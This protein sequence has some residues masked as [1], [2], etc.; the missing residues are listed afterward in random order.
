VL[1][2]GK[3]GIN[4]DNFCPEESKRVRY[5]LSDWLWEPVLGC[6]EGCEMCSFKT[7]PHLYPFFIESTRGIPSAISAHISTPALR[8]KNT[9]LACRYTDLFSPTV[10]NGIKRKV[11]EIIRE[12]PSLNFIIPT[13]FPEETRSFLLPRNVIVMGVC[14]ADHHVKLMIER[15]DSLI[16]IVEAALF[17]TPNV[18]LGTALG[19][20]F[21]F[22]EYD[23]L[24][25]AQGNIH[26]PHESEPNKF[27]ARNR[28]FCDKANIA[29]YSAYL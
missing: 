22:D 28:K 15:L 25:V 14:F 23:L 4:Y 24:F 21:T 3:S 8:H 16:G 26:P 12:A 13:R 17:V 19:C 11:L 6:N 2:N 5:E 1:G 27:V 29:F 20:D 9:V 10:E 18:D 7:M